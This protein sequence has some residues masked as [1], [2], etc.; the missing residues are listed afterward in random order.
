MSQ[1]LPQ[2]VLLPG[3]D[4]TGELFLDFIAEISDEFETKD[5]RYSTDKYQ[6]YSELVGLIRVSVPADAPFVLVAESF[7]TP[8]A[9]HYAATKPPNLKGLVLCAGF[10][11][12]PLRGWRRFVASIIAP[13]AFRFTLPTLACKLFL[14]G[15]DAPASLVTA[16]RSAISI[17]RP[18]VLSGRLRSVLRCDFRADLAQV[19]V[20]ILCIRAERDRLVG[21]SCLEEILRVKPET[22]VVAV[23]GPHLLLQREP[24]QTA[25]IV[26]GFIG[27][28]ETGES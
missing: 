17:V 16:V 11:T 23:S 24:A 28:L 1:K 10:A 27:Q 12:S 6:S 25:R 5:V 7:S 18:N 13:I 14:V 9:I 21:A 26:A 15:A 4:G 2:A 22:H 20:P 3:M 8:L 19:D